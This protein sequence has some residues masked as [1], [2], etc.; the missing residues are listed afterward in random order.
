MKFSKHVLI[1]LAI[2][3]ALLLGC[4]FSSDNDSEYDENEIAEISC[5]SEMLKD[6]SGLKIVC[7]GDS[8]G[9]ILNGKDGADGKNG[10]DGKDGL[11]GKD[12]VDG[13]PG[14]NGIDG[15]PGKDGSSPIITTKIIDPTEEHPNGGT[16]VIVVFVNKDGELETETVTLW[17][18]ENGT[19][20]KDGVNGADGEQGPQGD[21]GDKGEP[22]K[23]GVDG[24]PGENGIDGEPGK[25]GENGK[26]GA[27]GTDGEAG[28][29]G[30]SPTISTKPLEPTADHPNGGNEISITYKDADGEIKTETVTI[31]NGAD[32]A[33][34]PQGDKGD[35]G[36][37]GPQG[38]QGD[39][40][41]DGQDYM[42]SSSSVAESSSSS[43]SGA[44][45]SSSENIN[46]SSSSAESE[47]SSSE[48]GAES[49][50]SENIIE[51][52][53][54]TE[55]E[56]SSSESNAES[57]SSENIIESSSSDES[58]SSSSE[59]SS[60]SA[61]E[62]S[63]SSSVVVELSQE[64]K[65]MRK[66]Q[67]HFIP[68]EDVFDCVLPDEK[69]V[70]VIRHGER[71]KDASGSTGDLNEYGKTQASYLGK[72][73]A[74]QNYEFNYMSTYVYRTMRTNI[75]ISQGKGE[76]FLTWDNVY[77]KT[78]RNYIISEDFTEKWFQK[79]DKV[80]KCAGIGSWARFTKMAYEPNA[81]PDDFYNVDEKVE[82][83]INKH[84][85]YNNIQKTT[86]VISH[87]QFLAP[88]LIAVTDRKIGLDAY[89]YVN[90]NGYNNDW[91]QGVFDHWPNYLTGAA[92]IVNEN[93]DRVFVPV[94]GLK[95][96]YLGEHC[97][98]D[99]NETDDSG[100]EIYT[101][102]K[103]KG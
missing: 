48:A 71:W 98:N 17:N 36:P 64:C 46:E 66:T 94:R 73:L 42:P 70:F 78:A 16:M 65:E 53:S 20:G 26:D 18:G 31:W 12:G 50:N 75:L 84:F 33:Q 90:A 3:V 61:E 95:T 40:G 45:S 74:S 13:K 54:S 100:K 87:D 63:S 51:S 10:A 32:G 103:W 2:P 11:N 43:E 41:K 28:A 8:I 49:S 68:L 15:E 58:E 91:N 77:G 79:K 72:K 62:I 39:P 83:L 102:K 9:V 7:N 1:A 25:D 22:G 86:M 89:N 5:K 34:G 47:S 67:D 99:A 4:N 57:S 69:V 93:N 56:S 30:Y 44:E 29:D 14:E 80:D 85:M 19:D 97:P 38:P 37:Q 6:S 92:I 35:T 24:K 101:C 21:K 27:D 55:S 60:S 23:D 52:S 81:C 96:G 59:E 88:F 76:D 82:E